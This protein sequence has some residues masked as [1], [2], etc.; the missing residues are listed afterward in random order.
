MMFSCVDGAITEETA[1]DKMAQMAETIKAAS[2]VNL[3]LDNATDSEVCSVYLSGI[4]AM[5]GGDMTPS[6]VMKAVQQKA[7]Q[8]KADK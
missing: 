2:S 4:Q 6:E 5:V 8:V 3:W 1:T 7:A